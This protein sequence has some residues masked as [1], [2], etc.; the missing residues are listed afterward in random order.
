MPEIQV[1]E[2]TEAHPQPTKRGTMSPAASAIWKQLRQDQTWAGNAEISLILHLSR[3]S[4]LL[5]NELETT[6]GFSLPQ[7]RILFEAMAP[8]GTSQS[9]LHKQYQIDPGSITR[10]VQ[11]M[12][13]D[14]L[15]TRRPD[16]AD[17]RL[18]RVYIT[19]KG[20]EVAAQMPSQLSQAE[21]DMSADL[22]DDEVNLFHSMLERLEAR[23][24]RRLE[25]K[26]PQV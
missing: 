4:R 5:N 8:E 18:M 25:E 11:T 24:Y 2:P 20:R 19:A 13:R 7:I 9:A 26:E 10:T 21:R 14:G 16:E 17:N 1:K 12:E 15:V 23:L 22:S 6:A 3:I